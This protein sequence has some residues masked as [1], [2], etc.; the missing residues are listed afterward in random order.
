MEFKYIVDYEDILS[1]FFLCFLGP[2]SKEKDFSLVDFLGLICI[3]KM[4]PGFLI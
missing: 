3:Q 1:F 2:I 4:G